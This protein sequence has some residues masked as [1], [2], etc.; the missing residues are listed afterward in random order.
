MN[1]IALSI[2]VGQLGPLFGITVDGDGFF[3]KIASFAS[4][5]SGTHAL[6]LATGVA[7]FVLLRVLKHATPRIP[8]PLIVV[9]AAIAA[10]YA[11]DFAARGVAIVGA[12]PGGFPLP[13]L[14]ASVT[15]DD[16]GSLAFSACGI[17][18]VSFCS[19]MPTARLRRQERL[20][21]RREPGLHRPRFLEPCVRAGAGFRG[22]RRRFANRGR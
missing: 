9:A 1:G 10:A 11:F 19:M 6:T 17:V 13:Q 8:A 20:P 15:L 21:D 18:L 12:V 16:L 2:L 7:L 14:P 4:A 3:R 22:Q 5:V